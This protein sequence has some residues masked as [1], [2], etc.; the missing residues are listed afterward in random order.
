[1]SNFSEEE[2]AFFQKNDDKISKLIARR[3]EFLNEKRI[4]QSNR[5]AIIKKTIRTERI[6]WMVGV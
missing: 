4:E 3:S 1:M 6:I 2:R 5:I